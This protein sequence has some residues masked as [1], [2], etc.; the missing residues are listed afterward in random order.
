MEVDFV[1]AQGPMAGRGA[2]DVDQLGFYSFGKDGVTDL[3]GRGQRQQLLRQ[4]EN[5]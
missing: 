2:N 4:C 1:L 3:A 5:V